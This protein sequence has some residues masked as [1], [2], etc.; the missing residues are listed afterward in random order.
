[1]SCCH[2]MSPI[3]KVTGFVN[4]KVIVIYRGLSFLIRGAPRAIKMGDCHRGH[5]RAPGAPTPTPP[6]HHL[7]WFHETRA[8]PGPARRPAAWTLPRA[9]RK[10]ELVGP[11]PIRLPLIL[12]H[13]TSPKSRSSSFPRRRPSTCEVRRPPVH[14][15]RLRRTKFKS[16]VSCLRA[17]RQRA[18]HVA[19]LQCRWPHLPVGVS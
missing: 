6:G 9:L 19:T 8:S 18:G 2:L 17:A 13:E 11:A 16:R 5:L 3:T 4:F 14:R 7:G 12:R 10:R 1:M 15:C